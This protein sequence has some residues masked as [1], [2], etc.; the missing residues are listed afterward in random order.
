M[1]RRLLRRAA[2][3]PSLFYTCPRCGQDVD[4]LSAEDELRVNEHRL[5][6]L[7]KQWGDSLEGSTGWIVDDDGGLRPVAE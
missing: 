6:H 7:A 4:R 1:I 2:P 3:E 5:L